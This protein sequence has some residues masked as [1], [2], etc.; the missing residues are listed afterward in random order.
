MGTGESPAPRRPDQLA[1]CVHQSTT[2]GLVSDKMEDKD[3]EPEVVLC[4]THV[5][6]LVHTHKNILS[7]LL[8]NV[9]NL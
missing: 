6:S 7:I 4:G 9:T 2:R 8:I 1:W 5:F 3:R